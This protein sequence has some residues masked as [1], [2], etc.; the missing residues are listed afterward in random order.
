MG[1]RGG[2]KNGDGKVRRRDLSPASS[3]QPPPSLRSPRARSRLRPPPS[4]SLTLLGV[5]SLL[6]AWRAGPRLAL[7]PQGLRTPGGIHFL[8]PPDPSSVIL[9]REGG[10]A[11]LPLFGLPCW[12]DPAS[13]GSW[14]RRLPEDGHKAGRR[15]ALLSSQARPWTRAY[16]PEERARAAARSDPCSFTAI[17]KVS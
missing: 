8:D 15:G 10:A 11:P 16:H 2:T 14:V 12:G 13:A 5:L 6:E 4:P 9:S 1:R 3:L 7:Q 17:A